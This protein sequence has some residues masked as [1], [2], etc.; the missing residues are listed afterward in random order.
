MADTA[1]TADT[2]ASILARY[3]READTS[4][5]E[6]GRNS[7]AVHREHIESGAAVDGMAVD[8]T[9]VTGAAA[10]DSSLSVDL[11]TRTTGVGTLLG[12]GAFLTHTRITAIILIG[13]ILRIGTIMIIT[14]APYQEGSSLGL[15]PSWFPAPA[16][17]GNCASG[18]PAVK[19]HYGSLKSPACSCV[20]ITLPA[21]S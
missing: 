19:S 7:A 9:V 1:D 10:A 17:L 12:A 13:I 21:A 16:S 3:R 15:D 14:I 18:I 8:G 4:S 20:S 6:A 2:R 11:V 5:A